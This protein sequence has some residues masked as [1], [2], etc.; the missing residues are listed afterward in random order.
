MPCTQA[1]CTKHR[2]L[3]SW[4][5]NRPPLENMSD[6]HHS[7]T[8]CSFQFKPINL[9]NLRAKHS[10]GKHLSSSF[11]A[12]FLFL[13]GL[14]TSS[15]ALYASKLH[16][17]QAADKKWQSLCDYHAI[18]FIMA[19][20]GR[21]LLYGFAMCIHLRSWM[22]PGLAREHLSPWSVPVVKQQQQCAY[23]CKIVVFSRAR[24]ISAMMKMMAW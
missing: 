6:T 4:G 23:T 18:I 10:T 21:A 15:Y 7:S 2:R 16:K 17:T 20:M 9:I 19:E 1:N 11:L 24:P 5:S 3:L 12:H 13:V 22:M 8:K 14:G